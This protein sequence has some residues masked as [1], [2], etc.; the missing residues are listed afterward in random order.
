MNSEFDIKFELKN[1]KQNDK[2]IFAFDIYDILIVNLKLNSNFFINGIFS[3]FFQKSICE[4]GFWEHKSKGISLFYDYIIGVKFFKRPLLSLSLS[5]SLWCYGHTNCNLIQM[6]SLLKIELRPPYNLKIEA[7]P[8]WSKA[9]F[10]RLFAGDK[11]SLPIQ[12][13]V[14][15]VI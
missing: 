7:W 6:E 14:L 1:Q 11:I 5:L 4:N 15:E 2:L 12:L 10:S 9:N 8:A 3:F 13:T